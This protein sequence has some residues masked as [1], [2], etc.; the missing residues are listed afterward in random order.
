M[1]QGVVWTVPPSALANAVE[2]YGER[3]R[4]AVARVGEYIAALLE[5]AAKTNAGWTDRTGQARQGLTGVSVA[6]G[7]L[8]SIYL[9]HQAAHGKWLEVAHGGPYRIIIP[10]LTAHYGEIMR[11]IG[12]VLQGG[13]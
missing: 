4:L 3:V 2:R 8:V 6:A 9:Y 10:T 13:V 7:D 1:T 11:L 5:T 12:S